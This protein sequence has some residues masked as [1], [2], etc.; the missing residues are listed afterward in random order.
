MYISY[1]DGAN[2]KPFQL[3]LPVVPIT[4]LTIKKNDLIVATQGRSFWSLDDLTCSTTNGCRH[5][6]KNLHVFT[7]N[8]AYLFKRFFKTW[9]QKMQ[10]LILQTAGNKL[11]PEKYYGL[12]KISIEIL[13]K[14]KKQNKTFCYRC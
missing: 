4:D 10:A 13:D 2:W 9:M 12:C 5:N 11:L 3:N 7:V 1:D 8:D 14:N 6:N